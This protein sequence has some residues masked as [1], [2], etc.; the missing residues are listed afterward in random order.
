[1]TLRNRRY[2]SGFQ[3][4]SYISEAGDN[5]IYVRFQV[6]M[7]RGKRM[8]VDILGFDDSLIGEDG[9]VDYAAYQ[10]IV[11]EATAKFIEKNKK[12]KIVSH[13]PSKKGN[14][15]NGKHIGIDITV[16]PPRGWKG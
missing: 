2:N 1:M 8:V 5:K 4:S 6:N 12:W 13:Y 3:Y 10:R 16:K 15:H 14:T 7:K 11:K 9:L